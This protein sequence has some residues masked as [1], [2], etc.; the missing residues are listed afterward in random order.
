MSHSFYNV[1]IHAVFATKDRQQII[2]EEEDHSA[3][4]PIYDGLSN[5]IANTLENE[6]YSNEIMVETLEFNGQTYWIDAQH[7]VMDIETFEHIGLY[8]P[9]T[10]TII[11]Y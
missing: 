8:R 5:I 9:E 10:E 1:W 3:I 6:D 2:P 4:M 7:N 11:F